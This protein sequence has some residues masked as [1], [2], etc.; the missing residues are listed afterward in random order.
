MGRDESEIVR[1]FGELGYRPYGYAVICDSVL[2]ELGHC[3]SCVTSF[4]D[5]DFKQ[6]R[7]L[8]NNAVLRLY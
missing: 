6:L 1:T 3:N 8:K 7:R 4:Q 5:V 2:M